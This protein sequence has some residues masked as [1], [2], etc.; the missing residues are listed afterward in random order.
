[1][2]LE[3]RRKEYVREHV[4]LKDIPTWME[5]TKSKNQSDDMG[6]RI[7]SSTIVRWLKVMT[8]MNTM[9]KELRRKARKA[10][11]SSGGDRRN[12]RDNEYNWMWKLPGADTPKDLH[13]YKV[14][15]DRAD[16]REDPSLEMMIETIDVFLKGI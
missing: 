13:L 4:P 8:W 10:R 6:L 1:M 16:E 3:D 11:G 12:G 9:I 5:E 15:S 14:P 2:T 7:L